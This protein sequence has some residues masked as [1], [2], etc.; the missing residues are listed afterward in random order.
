MALA[1][2]KI[3]FKVVKFRQGFVTQKKCYN[4][5]YQKIRKSYTLWK[6]KPCLN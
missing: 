4:M 6:R 1:L 2:K 3:V 5:V